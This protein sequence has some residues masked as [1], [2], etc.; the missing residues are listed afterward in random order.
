MT[1]ATRAMT[2]PHGVLADGRL[3]RAVALRAP[4]GADEE[5]LLDG[6]DVTRPE[7]VTRL[8]ER[9]VVKIG[10]R[11]CSPELAR[12]LTCGDREA[13]LLHLRRATFGDR[14]ACMLECP[15][16]GEAM[17]LDLSVAELL[18]E[19]GPAP[20]DEQEMVLVDGSVVRFR[21]PT[22][23][24]LEAAARAGE[25]EDGVVTLLERCISEPTS[26]SP[27]AWTELA[28]RMASLDP[29]AEIRLRL[30]CPDCGHDFAALLD[31]A[32]LLLDE[33]A[34]DRAELYGEVHEIALRYHWSEADILALEVP[35]RRQYLELLAE[36][37]RAGGWE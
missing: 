25:V 18:V 14:L 5:W 22:G 21:L 35:R 32:A 12:G 34:A 15:A 8:L 33:L 24:D 17:D 20:R 30:R 28:A 29:Q 23:G 2:L 9:C 4:T 10:R 31:A 3:D 36:S 7:R 13:L 11:R 26:L 19:P 16:C 27:E 6:E 37:A 1:P